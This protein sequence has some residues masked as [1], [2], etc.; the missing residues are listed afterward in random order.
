[1]DSE[2]PVTILRVIDKEV[3]K[4]K[5]ANFGKVKISTQNKDQKALESL[6]REKLKISKE[7]PVNKSILLESVDRQMAAV[8]KDIEQNK[9]ATDIK[10]LEF[11]KHNKGKAAAVF[12]LKDKVIGKKKAAQE[13][14]VIVDPESGNEVYSPEDIKRVSLNFVVNLLKTKEP[15]DEYA[16]MVATRRQLH[17]E[18]MSEAI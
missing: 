13:Q 12:S 17:Y 18:R 3:T 14:V 7:N 5:F 15:K 16:D 8:L 1:M 4:V 10:Q 9:F 2:D 11:L 6:Q